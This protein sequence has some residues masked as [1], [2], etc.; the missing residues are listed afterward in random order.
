MQ[1]PTTS[2][3]S[4]K[5]GP[6]TGTPTKEYGERK[7]IGMKILAIKTIKENQAFVIEGGSPHE[8]L[9]A[10]PLTKLHIKSLKEND[11][12]FPSKAV[13]K[14]MYPVGQI[15]RAIIKFPAY[16]EIGPLRFE[17]PLKPS[18]I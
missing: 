13:E 1:T 15:Y 4:K 7:R 6:N 5:P 17:G 2:P 9:F 18:E 8:T 16:T 11:F 10:K 3:A 14:Q 12:R